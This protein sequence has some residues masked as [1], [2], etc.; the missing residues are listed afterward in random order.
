MA[1]HPWKTVTA[2]EPE[3]ALALARVQSEVFASG[4][5]GFA[6]LMTKAFAALG[7]PSP[8]L[9]AQ[10]VARSID[11]ARELGAESG[12]YSVLDVYEI[13]EVPGPGVMGPFSNEVLRE[14]VGSEQ[15]TLEAVESRLGS[16]YALLDRGS[17][18]YVVC[19]DGG[20]P[21]HY[22]FVGMSFD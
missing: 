19:H 22:V 6:N 12:T 10:R 13:G 14:K 2:F 3:I 5:Y 21:S 18:G 20:E 16:L 1:G 17:S 8:P 7:R 15:P 9:P 11:E 4:E